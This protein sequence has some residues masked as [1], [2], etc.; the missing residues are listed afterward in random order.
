MK[1]TV[2]NYNDFWEMREKNSINDETVETYED[3]LFISILDSANWFAKRQF[4]EDHKN[5]L[6]LQF[7]DVLHDGEPS[8]TNNIDTRAFDNTD[9]NKVMKFL[10]DNQDA[11][12]CVVHCAAGISRSGAIGQFVN[13][14]FGGDYAMFKQR[15]PQIMPNEMIVM[16]LNRLMRNHGN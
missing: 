11:E 5:V 14:Y 3:T 6:T 8:P 13:D 16:M 9:G 4:Q 12:F 7:D 1:V 10:D 2:L 15:N